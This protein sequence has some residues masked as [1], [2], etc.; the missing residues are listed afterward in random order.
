[1]KI[2]QKPICLFKLYSSHLLANFLKEATLFLAQLETSNKKTV[3]R[4]ILK[5][6]IS[7][8]ILIFRLRFV[9]S[10]KRYG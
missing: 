3:H 10:F 2:F 1:M 7:E 5:K 6:C 9:Y 4:R 8:K